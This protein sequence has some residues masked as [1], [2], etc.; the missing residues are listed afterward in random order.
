MGLI[1]KSGK[2]IVYLRT[3][4]CLEIIFFSE[5]YKQGVFS[6]KIKDIFQRY[7]IVWLC[8][9]ILNVRRKWICLRRPVDGALGEGTSGLKPFPQKLFFFI[10]L[11]IM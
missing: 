1:E 11:Y 4:V 7:S 9:C 5:K 8:I 6:T 3:N 10:C 2:K